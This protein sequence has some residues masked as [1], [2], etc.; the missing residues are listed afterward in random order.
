MIALLDRL[1]LFNLREFSTHWGRTAA[2][3]FVMAVSAAFV[4]TVIGISGSLTGSV[5]QLASGLAGNAALEVSGVTDAGFAQTV[6]ADVA[7]VPGVAAAVPML[8]A[9]VGPESDQLLVLGVDASSAALDS[10]LKGAVQSRDMAALLSVPDGVLAGPAA[11]HDKGDVIPVGSN[12]VTVA[13]VLHGA[14]LERLNGGHYLIAPLPLAQRIT[15]RLGQLDSILIVADPNIDAAQL[16]SAVTA[17]VAGRALVAE[18]SARAA[19]TGNGI[20]MLRFIAGMGA[21]IAFVVAAFLIYNTMSMA[22]AG[23]RPVIS[24]LRAIGGRKQTIVR[25]VIAEALAFGL[26]GGMIGGLLGIVSGRYAVGLLPGAFTQLT[27]VR[28]RYLLPWYAVPA[29]VAAAT[30]TNVAASAVAARQVYRVSPVEA[31]APVGAGQAD[32]VPRRLRL[33][34]AL[35]GVVLVVATVVIARAHLG[36]FASV[37]LGSAFCAEIA[38]GFAATGPIVWLAGLLARRF[39]PAG[40]LA[41]VN[42]DRAP[43][44]VWATLM[45]VTIAV[46]MTI[47][48]TGANADGVRS[49]RA[50]FASLADTDVWVTTTPEDMVPTGLLPAALPDRIAAVPGV[51]RVTQGQLAFATLGGTK[52]L[53]YGVEPGSNYAMSR[54]LDPEIERELQAGAGVVLSR[55]LARALGVSTGD[56]LIVQTPSGEKHAK[57]LASVSYFSALTGTAAVSLALMREWFSRPGATTLQIDAAPGTDPHELLS[58]IGQVVPPELHVYSG[59]RALDGVSQAMEQGL[60]LSRIMLFI[61]SVIAAMG[62][63]N[64]LTLALL[65][66]RRELGI[67][68]AVGSSRRFALRMVLA[69]AAAIGVIGAALGVAFGLTNQYLYSI[70]AADLMGIDVTFRPGPLLLVFTLG[71]L[72]LSLLGSIPPALRAARL[73][74]VDAVSAD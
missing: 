46:A 1:R 29:A 57:V 42:I 2:S 62:L 41:G 68:R 59:A 39:G 49:A 67:L 55:D 18:P 33:S 53:V 19:Q 44:R 24:M 40:V 17:A 69:E 43:R 20:V 8:R 25:D 74:I 9:A 65:E 26:I 31:L 48:I 51:A 64:T 5:E 21:G 14:D 54:S 52:A 71:A 60:V 63:L 22:L 15:G 35:L 37:A 4:V 70:L 6:R 3:V 66:R 12:Q 56:D 27:E 38:L 45:T 30:L 47:T 72:G 16:N 73:D 28:L 23:R 36:L 34:A 50:S 13:A 10:D 7:A 32:V 61:V 58:A 11:G